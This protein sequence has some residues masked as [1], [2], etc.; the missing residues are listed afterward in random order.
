MKITDP[1]ALI[2][3]KIG[4]ILL[5]VVFRV[6][7]HNRESE[8]RYDV[9][10]SIKVAAWIHIV[11]GGVITLCALLAGFLTKMS[12]EWSLAIVSLATVGGALWIRTAIRLIDGYRSARWWSIPFLIIMLPCA[13]FVGWVCSPIAAYC[14]FISATSRKFYKSPAW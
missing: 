2:L 11:L 3:V 4:V 13:P 5:M 12:T 14:V 1:T 8:V 7:A 9:P 10:S 6:W